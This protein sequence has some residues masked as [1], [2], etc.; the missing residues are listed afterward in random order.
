MRR[1]PTPDDDD[2]DDMI[3]VCGFC[4]G[5]LMTL[6]VLG[7]LVWKRCRDCGAEFH[8]PAPP[9]DDDAGGALSEQPADSL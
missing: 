1:P 8:Q 5:P 9:A 6:G 7:D 2:A 3:D 4:Y